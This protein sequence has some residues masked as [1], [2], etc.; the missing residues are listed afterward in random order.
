MVSHYL[1]GI[2]ENKEMCVKNVIFVLDLRKLY[3][4]WRAEI[5][6]NENKETYKKD[7]IVLIL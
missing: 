5:G 3:S 7:Y 2:N 1:S 6:I 4:C